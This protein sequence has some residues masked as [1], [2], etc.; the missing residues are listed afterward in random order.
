MDLYLWQVS[1]NIPHNTARDARLVKMNEGSNKLSER[2]LEKCR[3][4]LS[5][6]IFAA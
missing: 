1:L 3:H 2:L 4:N 6:L 5:A